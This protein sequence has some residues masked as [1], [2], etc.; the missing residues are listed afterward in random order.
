[1]EST[2][3]SHGCNQVSGLLKWTFSP[4]SEPHSNGLL[5][6]FES[7]PCS[8][9]SLSKAQSQDQTSADTQGSANAC[10]YRNFVGSISQKLAVVRTQVFLEMLFG[11]FGELVTAT[12][13]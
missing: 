10:V 7:F 12:S 9:P 1:M 3:A 11:E 8:D 6:S 13:A 2:S 4:I 5:P